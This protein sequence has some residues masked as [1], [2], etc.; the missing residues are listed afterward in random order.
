[1]LFR[2]PR[3]E[4]CEDDAG[5]AAHTGTAVG[6]MIELYHAGLD[7]SKAI[8]RADAEKGT[9]EGSAHD[10]PLAD[11]PQASA[12][13]EAYAA[14]PRNP[15]E[16]IWPGSCE[17]EVHLTLP[18]D[19][20]DETGEP[21]VLIGHIDQVRRDRGGR[22]RLWDVKSGRAGGVQ[23]L[24]EYAWQLMA[25]ALACSNTFGEPILPGGV[26][27]VRGYEGRVKKPSGTEDVFFEAPWTLDDCRE[28][29]AGVAWYVGRIRAGLIPLRPGVHCMWCPAGAPHLCGPRLGAHFCPTVPTR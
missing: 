7:L 20:D 14:D 21:V 28:A 13:V 10:Y 1:M 27:R 2:D 23:M 5:E 19:P 16:I 29:M 25:Y 6:R 12:W 26:I 8:A 22:W 18:A 4:L 9:G 24:Y 17:R 15:R 3:F 11:I